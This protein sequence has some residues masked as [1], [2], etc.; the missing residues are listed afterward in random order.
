LHKAFHPDATRGQ[1]P[2]SESR[3]VE[4]NLAFE[5]L[6]LDRDPVSFRNLRKAYTARRPQTAYQNAVLLKNQLCQQVDRENVLAENFL[7]YLA[8]GALRPGQT[9]PNNAVKLSD[10]GLRLG[11]L[12][13]AI[14]NNIRQASWVLG[15]NYKQVEIDQDGLLFIKPVGRSR[16]TQ[17]NFLRLLGCVPTSRLEIAPLLEKTPEQFF[18]YPALGA[19]ND[20]PGPRISVVNLISQE[21][22]KKHVLKH[23]E[24][25][26]LER[27]YLFSL[28]KAEF[29][30]TGHIC[31]EG[32]IV[33]LERLDDQ[34]SL[35]PQP[36]SG[37]GS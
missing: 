12:D 6:N 24:P 8:Q 18:R 23:L 7:S 2:D 9:A 3:T 5:A 17:V 14:N 27:A 1:K 34:S 20:S 26:L 33:K 15:A 25:F 28:N 29:S 4:L 30:T 13:V 21:N 10:P 36:R 19:G 11:L 37:S 32:V 35:E 22:F 16:L 31:L